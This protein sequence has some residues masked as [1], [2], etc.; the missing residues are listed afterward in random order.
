[1]TIEIN[2]NW[3][4]RADPYQ[5]I[6]EKSRT[7]SGLKGWEGIAYWHDL[8]EAAIWLAERQLRDLDTDYR[9]DDL[10]SLCQAVDS[11]RIEITA[12]V[13]AAG[14]TPPHGSKK[15]GRS[16]AFVR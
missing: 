4:I 15:K 7:K 12:A 16:D 10:S 1:M 9:I 11:L 6:V 3:R 13:R 2:A 14:L 8:S 5:W